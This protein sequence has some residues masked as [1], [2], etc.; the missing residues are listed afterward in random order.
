MHETAAA[1]FPVP[2]IAQLPLLLHDCLLVGWQARNQADRVGSV[3]WAILPLQ[4]ESS[5]H[6]LDLEDL[7]WNVPAVEVDVVELVKKV[8]E[9]S[10]L[11]LLLHSVKVAHVAQRFHTGLEVSKLRIIE[12]LVHKVTHPSFGSPQLVLADIGALSMILCMGLRFVR[13]T[14]HVSND[15]PFSKLNASAAEPTSQ[16]LINVLASP[17][18]HFRVVT[19][20]LVPPL[21][22]DG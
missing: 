9:V 3:L 14:E 19:L 15:R 13:D 5:G 22:A 4:A 2:G 12:D 20:C 16:R 1:F 7:L 17:S 6:F 10:A 8:S 18:K 21:P 11:Q